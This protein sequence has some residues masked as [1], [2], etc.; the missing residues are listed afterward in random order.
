[1]GKTILHNLVDLLPEEDTETIYNVL[2][3]FIPLDD[4]MADE[5]KSIEQA[6]REIADGEVAD[7]NEINWNVD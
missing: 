4:P 1:M 3:H 6:E 5:K 7:F 2:I